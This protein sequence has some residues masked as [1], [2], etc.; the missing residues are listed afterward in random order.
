MMAASIPDRRSVVPF[1]PVQIDSR[2]HAVPQRTM[3]VTFLA[4]QNGS[5]YENTMYFYLVLDLTIYR[6]LLPL[7]I[8][9]HID[10]TTFNY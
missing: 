6:V 4:G 3:L 8:T 5:V 2:T 9:V 7:T 1:A 10:G